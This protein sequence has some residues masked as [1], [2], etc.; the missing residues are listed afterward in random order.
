MSSANESFVLVSPS[1]LS[2]NPLKLAAELAEVEEAGADWHHIDVMDGHFVPNLTFGLPLIRAVK[3]VSRIP[4]DVHIMIENP[5]ETA[6]SYVEAGADILTFHVEA[7]R[8]PHRL[9]GLIREAGAKAGIALNPGTPLASVEALLPCVDMVLLMSVNPGFGGQSFIPQTSG[10]V[11]Q[12]RDMLNQ[13]LYGKILIQVDGG[14]NQETACS[15]RKEGA[16]CLVA[17]SW[18]YGAQNRKEAVAALRL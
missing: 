10:R 9:L 12:L 7:A 17:G 8:H 16:D 6:L 2:A 18:V 1:I 15:V 3:R 11:R 5:N 4:L 13:R 14:I